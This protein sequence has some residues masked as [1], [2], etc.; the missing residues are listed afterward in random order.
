[1][2]TISPQIAWYSHAGRRRSNQDA[3]VARRLPTG[4]EL[5]AVADGM[6]GHSAGEVASEMALEVLVA[7]LEAGA[8]L[9]SAVTEANRRVFAAARE[10]ARWQGMGTTLVALLRTGDEY[11]IANVGDSRAYRIDADGIRQLTDDHSYVAEARRTG[12]MTEAQLAASPWRNALTRSVGTDAGVEVDLFGP[13]P[14][15]SPHAVLLCSDG[16]YKVVADTVLQEYVLS[17]DDPGQA[18]EVLTALAYRRG[19][20]DNISV[21]VAEFASLPR[22]S[23]VVTLP[24][25]MRIGAAAQDAAPVAARASAVGG[26]VQPA[27]E[28]W[29]VSQPAVAP[30]AA[31]AP[32]LRQSRR[33]T[34]GRRRPGSTRGLWA[35]FAVLLI[36][37]LLS[38]GVFLLG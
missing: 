25:P 37:A 32:A 10:N 18:A 34:R 12:T 22:R 17:L 7:E 27:A 35:L 21:A 1:M 6:G 8:E 14:A 2:Q 4:A 5:V 20:D 36:A 29:P 9:A 38:G 31:V 19:S 33:A 23:P 3:V 16:L 24:I 15:T 13:F 30:R 26:A 28:A 11:C